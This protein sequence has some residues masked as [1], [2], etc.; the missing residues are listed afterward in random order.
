MTRR[1]LPALPLVALA[2]CGPSHNTLYVTIETYISAVSLNESTRILA[3]LAPAQRELQAAA[4]DQRAAIEKKYRDL[5]EQGF[6]LWETAK[7]AGRLEPDTLGIA[8]IRGIGLGKEGA[9]ALP[10]GVRMESGNTRA[11]VTSRAITNY[12]RIAWD[13]LPTG[14]RMYLMGHPFGTVV[15]FAPGFDDAGR[16]ALLATVDLQ[17]S[18]VTL[19]GVARPEAAPSDWYVEKVEA[20]PA[21]GTSWSPP[22]TAP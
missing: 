1:L 21:T 14:G 15:N 16:L 12:D 6:I 19:P 8:L 5:I 18:L 9:A 2:A 13:A 22:S 20:L 4:P 11:V 10:L 17:W 3:I 7:S